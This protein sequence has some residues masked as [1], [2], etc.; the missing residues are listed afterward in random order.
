MMRRLKRMRKE[1]EESYTEW[2]ERNQS[3]LQTDSAPKGKDRH[4]YAKPL[5][6][7][8]CSVCCILA[9]LLPVLFCRPEEKASE[10]GEEDIAFTLCEPEVFTD[11]CLFEFQNIV[12]EECIEGHITTT[13][14][15][16]V[17]MLYGSYETEEFYAELTATLV[18]MPNLKLNSY[19]LYQ[20]CN[21]PCKIGEYEFRYRLVEEGEILT[22][23]RVYTEID[24][25]QYYIEI[26]TLYPVDIENFLEYIIE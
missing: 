19:Y 13:Q 9:I 6:L 11:I 14:E 22:T 26:G 2:K 18:V 5:F 24:G 21:K 7:S 12:I 3:R 16:G 23:Y 10:Y 17:V 1:S 15:K 20:S 8:I 4:W 25:V